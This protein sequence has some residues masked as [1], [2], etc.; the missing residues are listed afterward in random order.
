MKRILL[1]VLSI[2]LVLSVCACKKDADSGTDSKRQFSRLKSVVISYEGKTEKYY[3]SWEENLCRFESPNGNSQNFY[4]LDTVLTFEGKFNPETKIFSIAKAAKAEEEGFELPIFMYD[5]N[6]RVVLIYNEDNPFETFAVSYDDNGLPSIDGVSLYDRYDKDSRTFS[7]EN[8][9]GHNN[10]VYFKNYE[11]ITIG[12][13]GQFDKVTEV[14]YES[15]NGEDY[16]K[17]K[18]HED[19]KKYTYDD[20]GNLVKY[21]M[22]SADVE[23]SF[24]YY[25]EYIS[26]IWERVIPLWYVDFFKMYLYSLLWYIE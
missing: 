9:R 12:K 23:I 10:G 6:E 13:N 25:D 22:L 7:F 19:Y 4:G 21:E 5:S 17:A 14:I 8:S 15:T 16:Y 11:Y 18:E 24:E 20:K 1:I 3:I 2:C 26:H